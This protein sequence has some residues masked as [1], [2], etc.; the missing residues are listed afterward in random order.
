V[1]PIDLAA[2]VALVAL[3]RALVAVVAL[4]VLARALGDGS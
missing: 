2:V 1:I 4:L 3:L